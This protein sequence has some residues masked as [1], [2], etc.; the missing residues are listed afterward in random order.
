MTTGTTSEDYNLRYFSHYSDTDEDYDWESP[1]W[2][3]FFTQVAK[4]T[5]TITGPATKT[6]DVGCAK[7]FLVMAFLEEGCDAY[8]IDISE[9]SI[10]EAPDPVRKRVRVASATEPLNEHFDLITCTEVLEH[11]SP[12]EAERAIDNI[13]ASTDR[14]LLSST[15]GDFDEPTHINIHPVADWVATFATRGFYRRT[16]VDTVFLAPWAVYLERAALQP[17]DVAHRYETYLYPLRLEVEAKKS[18]LLDASRTISRLESEQSRVEEAE[19]AHRRIRELE[20]ELLRLRD[21]AIACEAVAG[22]ARLERDQAVHRADVAVD[23]LA[24][25]HSSERWRVGGVVLSP[26]AAVKRRIGR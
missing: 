16:D 12:E 10:A 21:H 7:G 24:A 13:C 9:T 26:A 8:G 2:R 3:E 6:L 20:H 11:M 5:L 15:P 25:V 23:E 19:A 1:G 17:R 18:A 4:R 14:V 22:T